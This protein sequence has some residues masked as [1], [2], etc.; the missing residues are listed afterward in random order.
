MIRREFYR[1]QYECWW[2]SGWVKDVIGF[3][4]DLGGVDLE[5]FVCPEC[6]TGRDH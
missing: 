6:N 3:G 2:V 4:S 5:V 1:D